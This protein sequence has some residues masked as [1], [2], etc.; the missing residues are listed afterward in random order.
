[1]IV[2]KK[3]N[4]IALVQL[5]SALAI[6]NYHT[7]MLAIPVLSAFAK[8]GFVF[9]TAFVFLSG[10]LL[11]RSLSGS[12]NT[13][14]RGFI[15]KRVTRIYPSLH[16]AI[17]VIALIFL[18]TGRGVGIKS[19]VLA[20]TGFSYFF[21][22]SSLGPHLWFVSVI[23]VCYLVCIPTY[24][25]LKRRP[26]A[27]FVAAVGVTAALVLV[28]DGSF[29][30]IYS[31]VSGDVLYRLVYHYMVFSVGLYAGMNEL[32]RIEPRMRL[33]WIT[34]CAVLLPVYVWSQPRQE[35]GAIAVAAA[36]LLAIGIVQLLVTVG[37]VLRKYLS[38]IT[39]ASAITFEVYLVHYAVIQALDGRYH[40]QVIAYPLAFALS[41]GLALVVFMAS[42][43]YA[44]LLKRATASLTSTP[45]E[46][47]QNLSD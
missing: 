35:Y 14:F 31:E 11:S 13:T 12:P 42:R 10:F 41:L 22:D 44:R 16:V 18:S 24:R 37:G 15:A 17:L 46:G 32:G 7:S 40:G 45:T 30:G 33:A 4:E 3:S 39:V 28:R 19:L 29:Y 34:L 43:P 38:R 23:M 25:A 9:N 6:V 36:A 1:V 8:F 26:V 2:V 20:A 27:F 47:Q 5:V 21:G